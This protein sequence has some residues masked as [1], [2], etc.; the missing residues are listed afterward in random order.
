M[1]RQHRDDHEPQFEDTEEATLEGDVSYRAGSVRAALAH[2]PFRR[3]FAGAFLSNIGT[4]M[5]NVA[6]G[7]LAYRISRSASFVA[8]LGF[9]QLGPLLVLSIV[10]GALADAFDRKKLLIACQ[11]EQ[12]LLSFLLAV[13][14]AQD[15]PS[16]LALFLCVLAIGIGN[17][18]NAPAFSAV[19]PI[20]VG[21]RDLPGA[22]SLQSFQM[23]ATRV[24]GPAIGGLILP[25]IGAAGVFAVNAVTYVFVI[26]ALVA[27]P[28]PRPYPTIGEQGIRRLVSGFAYARRSWFVRECLLTMFC[29]SMFS[30]AF[31]G[32]LPV[33]AAENLGMDP[34][35]FAYGV[36]FAV[37]GLGAALGA[38]S[39]GTVFVDRAK[40]RMVPIALS[41]FAVL[42]GVFGF[43]RS[44]GPAYPALFFV[45]IAY[46]TTVTSLS[47]TLQ[48]HLDDNVR[49]RVMALWIM[50]FGG[51]VPIGLLIGGA[52]AERASVSFVIELGAAAAAVLALLR[53]TR[54]LVPRTDSA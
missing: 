48:E 51:T 27:V 10:G 37:F 24:I 23:N 28:I 3:V 45:G 41:A 33:L 11:A 9:A 15:D 12:M 7:V 40:H 52:I 2:G 16:R 42:L 36:L 19:L 30:L 13:I 20:L 38:I 6:L 1:S 39:V 26:G 5:Q 44:A 21:R 43:V 49:G 47:T 8:L 17:A 22:V 31:I 4:W 53:W 29:I 50:A 14:A 25:T 54:P 18:L 32:L 35:S 46:F 34:D